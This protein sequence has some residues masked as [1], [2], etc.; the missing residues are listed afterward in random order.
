MKTITKIIIGIAIAIILI[1]IG[2]RLTGYGVQEKNY[3][4]FAKCLTEKGV[5]MYGAFWCEHCQKMKAEFDDSW[6]Y[7]NYI[8]C[9]TPDGNSQTQE[10]K[11]AGIQGYPTWEFSDGTRVSGEITFEELALRSG[12]NLMK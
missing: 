1:I 12:C 6:K 10:C 7:I 8:E 5:K 4:E 9:S 2:M 3:D 11:Q